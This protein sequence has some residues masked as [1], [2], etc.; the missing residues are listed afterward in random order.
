[1]GFDEEAFRFERTHIIIT[2][3]TVV[4]T[5]NKGG[6][7]MNKGGPSPPSMLNIVIKKNIGGTK[8][9]KGQRRGMRV[10]RM[11]WWTVSEV[12]TPGRGCWAALEDIP[13]TVPGT[14]PDTVALL[15]VDQSVERGIAVAVMIGVASIMLLR[16][17][18][19]IN[20]ERGYGSVR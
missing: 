8:N 5:I 14:V 2:N 6:I 12:G 10:L 4:E 11:N 18:C 15:I 19:V 20:E 9:N 3:I 17:K 7:R 16:Y 13:D 1:M